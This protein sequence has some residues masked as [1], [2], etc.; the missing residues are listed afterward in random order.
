VKGVETPRGRNKRKVRSELGKRTVPTLQP[1]WYRILATFNENGDY[2]EVGKGREKK[3]EV[4]KEEDWNVVVDDCGE[5]GEWSPKG[6]AFSSFLL[7]L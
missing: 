4:D 6:F 7:N 1:Q 3:V 5:C 2:N